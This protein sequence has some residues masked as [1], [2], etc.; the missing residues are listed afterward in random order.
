MGRRFEVL[1]RYNNALW[2]DDYAH[3][4]T[5]VRVTL[6]ASRQRMQELNLN[7]KLIACF[8]PH[9]YTRLQALWD[10]FLD[11]FQSA[12]VVYIIDTYHAFEASIE[13]IDSKHFVEA[14][15]AKY[16]HQ[17]IA[18]APDLEALKRELQASAQAGDLVLSMGAGTITSLLRSIPFE[19]EEAS[20]HA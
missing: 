14:V 15:K 4:P 9:R 18:Y 2:V 13:G 3:H 20:A 12:D 7:G 11:A 16:P 17:Q 8:Q 1:G 19:A 10:G 5:E 6:E